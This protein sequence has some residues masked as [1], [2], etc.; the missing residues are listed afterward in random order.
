MKLEKIDIVTI[1]GVLSLIMILFVFAPLFDA[2]AYGVLLYYLSRPIIDRFPDRSK[3]IT[4]GGVLLLIITLAALLIG[5]TSILMFAEIS[6]VSPDS[7]VNGFISASHVANNF[8]SSHPEFN[9][10]IT[11]FT[12]HMDEYTQVMTDKLINLVIGIFNLT[13]T[14]VMAFVISFFML[15]DGPAF[16]KFIE[17]MVPKPVKSQ[18][19]RIDMNLE[20]IFV[21]S[22]FSAVIVG[23][24]TA[25]TFFIFGIKYPVLSG[26]LSAALQFIPMVGPQLFIIPLSLLELVYGNIIKFVVLIALAVFLFFVPDNVIKPIILR[27]TTGVHPLLV[28]LAFIGGVVMFGP[29]GFIYGPILLTVGDGLIHAWLKWE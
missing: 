27:R 20:G 8:L 26:V 21:G 2:I 23:I 17:R 13:I 4:S 25:L 9:P 22:I 5:Y 29:A 7:V 3:Y 11:S 1:L 14:L 10:L 16:R 6:T 12:H 15:I 28:L 24:I 18:L 19:D